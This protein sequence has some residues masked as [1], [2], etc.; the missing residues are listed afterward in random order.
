MGWQ[1]PS[2]GAAPSK[3]LTFHNLFTNALTCVEE[4]EGASLSSSNSVGS[5][6]KA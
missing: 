1:E 5:D 2:T 4:L 6:G 3:G